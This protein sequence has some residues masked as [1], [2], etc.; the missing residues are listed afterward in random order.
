MKTPKSEITINRKVS[1]MDIILAEQ[2]LVDNGIERDEA[3]TVLQAIGY[4]LLDT[5]LY[6][7]NE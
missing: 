5:E 1:V 6:P 3:D 2:V 7:E 4:A